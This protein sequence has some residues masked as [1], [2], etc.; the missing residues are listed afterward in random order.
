MKKLKF[1]SYTKKENMNPFRGYKIW[2]KR[3]KK[4]TKEL[5]SNFFSHGKPS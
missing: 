4:S 1:G 3:K 5:M 2:K